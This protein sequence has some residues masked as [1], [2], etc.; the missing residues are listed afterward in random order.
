MACSCIPFNDGVISALT[1]DYVL[2]D[3]AVSSI[4]A[5]EYLYMQKVNIVETKYPVIIH[6]DMLYL[7]RKNPLNHLEKRM[8]L[9]N[10]KMNTH[11]HVYT[12]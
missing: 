2:F 5:V 7:K 8:S 9:M 10:V 11:A 6:V 1:L 3:A 12:N 4:S